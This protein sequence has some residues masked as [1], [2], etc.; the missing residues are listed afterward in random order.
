MKIALDT[1]VLV[2]A[3]G[4]GDAARESAAIAIAA[5]L[6]AGATYLPSQV[7][8]ELFNVLVRRG[9]SRERARDAARDWHDTFSPIETTSSLVLAAM[10]LAV[11]HN[12][13]VWDALILSAAAEA[14]CSVLLS[15]DFQD[16]FSWN[17]VTVCNPFADTPHPLIAHLFAE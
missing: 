7:L 15:E 6:P 4:V 12:L 9:F 10:D 11:R 2:Y 3:E 13:R 1:N 8:G 16:G 17:G 14:D 5:S